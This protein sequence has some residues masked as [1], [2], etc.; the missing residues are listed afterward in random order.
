MIAK[1]AFPVQSGCAY[2]V[3][4]NFIECFDVT[5]VMAWHIY[6]LLNGCSMYSFQHIVCIN[7]NPDELFKPYQSMSI[8]RVECEWIA[9]QSMSSTKLACC[10][11]DAVDVQS[12][13]CA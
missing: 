7:K 11:A 4:G 6:C 9:K 3:S 5:P 12:S 10:A 8:K 13:P 1:P 2:A